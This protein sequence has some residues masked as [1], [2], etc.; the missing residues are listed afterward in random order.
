V[1]WSRIPLAKLTELEVQDRRCP[2]DKDLH[3]STC[4]Y[5]SGK[6][7]TVVAKWSAMVH[8]GRSM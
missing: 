3:Q 8:S 1:R 4:P 5:V 7:C 6:R 2:P